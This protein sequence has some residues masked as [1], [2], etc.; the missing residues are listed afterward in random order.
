MERDIIG[1]RDDRLQGGES[2][3]EKVMDR[4]KAITQSPSLPQIQKRFL[5]EFSKLDD[6]FKSIKSGEEV[7]PVDL[8][9]RLERL[10]EEIIQEVR[11]RELEES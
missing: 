4:G 8:S 10:Q 9:Q 5:E 11:E 2:L 1:L 6:K 7:F 3:L